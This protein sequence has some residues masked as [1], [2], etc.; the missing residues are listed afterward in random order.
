MNIK[1]L[2]RQAQEMQEKMQEKMKSMVAEGSSGGGMVKIL[3]SG[4]KKLQKIEISPEI[5]KVEEKETLEDLIMA[6]FNDANEKID[7]EIDSIMQSLG[8]GFG[9]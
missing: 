9:F 5:L 2:L 7:K 6:A 1:K 3:L 4:E 8:G